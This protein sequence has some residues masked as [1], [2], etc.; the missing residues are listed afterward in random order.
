M[1][2]AITKAFT[3]ELNKAFKANNLPYTAVYTLCDYSTEIMDYNSK[4]GKYACI[5]VYYPLEYY[6][7]PKFLTS[8]DLRLAYT[9]GDTVETYFRSLLTYIEI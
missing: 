6:A 4:I 2:L 3:K 1:R 8:Y 7:I 9:P 5:A